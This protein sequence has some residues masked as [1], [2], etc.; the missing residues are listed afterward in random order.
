MDW[1]CLGA[2]HLDI[3]LLDRFSDIHVIALQSLHVICLAAIS[4]AA[5]FDGLETKMPKHSK[6][7]QLLDVPESCKPSQEVKCFEFI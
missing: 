1:T 3:V 4:L 2:Q 6:L 5:K 7:V